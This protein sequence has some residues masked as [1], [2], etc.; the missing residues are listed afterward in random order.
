[1]RPALS[2]RPLPT[3]E[4]DDAELLRRVLS[5]DGSALGHLYDRHHAAVRRFLSRCTRHDVDDLV[6]E[7]FLVASSRAASFDGRPSARAWLVGIAA[8]LLQRRNRGWARF[9]RAV[10]RLFEGDPEPAAP[11]DRAL[12]RCE[13]VARLERALASLT[14]TRR[15]VLVM[16]EVEELPCDEIARSLDIP[17]GTVWTR[18]HH[19]RKALRAALAEEEAP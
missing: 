18:L 12:D 19:A 5:R 15:V 17:V 6:Q 2:L 7:T 8:H 14:E 13:D 16:F 10:E 1:M 9:T 4:P 11:P 3:V